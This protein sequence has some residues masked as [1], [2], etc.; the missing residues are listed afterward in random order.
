MNAQDAR[1]LARRFL[2]LPAQKRRIFLQ[3]LAR[4]KV[5]FAQFAIPA[6]VQAAER[7]LP[8]YAQQR[9]WFLWQLE[10][11]G[12]AYNLPGAVGLDGPLD[13][14]ALEQALQAL[15]ERHETLRSVLRQEGEQGLRLV[16][17]AQGVSIDFEDLCGLDTAAAEQ[18]VQVCAE[19][20]AQLP[21]DLEHGPLWRVRLLELGAER[22]V[23]LLTLHH[24][25]SDGWSMNVLIDEFIRCYDAFSQGQPMPL[26]ALPI[27]YA[28]Y[29]LWQRAWLEA[30]EQER[31]L[32]YWQQVLGDEHPV[33]ELPT[34][35][36][37]PATPSHR[38]TRHGFAVDAELAQQLRALAQQHQASLFMVLLA[39]FDALLYRYSGQG[40]LRVGVPIANRNRAEVEGLIGFFVNTQVL[41]CRIDEHLSVA[42]L[43]AQ[44]R[45][46]ALGAQAHQELP[47]ERLVEALKLERSLAHNPLFQVMYNHQPLVTDLTALQTASGIRFDLIQWQGR[48][49]QFDLSLDT[50]EKGG[51]L[52][53]ALTYAD[54][55][56]DAPTIQ[57]MAGHW[58][59]LL[60]AMVADAEQPVARLPMLGSAE[61]QQ[62]LHDWNPPGEGFD[63]VSR[64]DQC[65]AR[66]AAAHPDALALT[67]GLEQYSYGQLERWANRLAQRLVAA[68][69][70]PE[71]R[72]GVALP[73]TP[74]LLVSL[75]AVFKAGGAYVPLDPDYPAERVA[76]M[77]QDSAAH[78]VISEPEVAGRLALADCTEVLL[79]DGDEHSLAAWP[80]SA[81][82]NHAVAQN[83]AYVIYT[84]GSTGR[85]KGVAITHRNVLALLHWSR[86]VYTADDIQ[87]VLASTSICFDLSVWELFVTLAAGGSI[88]LARNALE[89][90]QLPA[91]D[92]VRLVNTVPSAITALLRDGLLPASVRIVNLA[93]EPLKQRVV[94]ALYA[95]PGLA[96]VFDL[97]GPSEDTTYSTWTRRQAGGRASIGRP[98]PHTAAYLLD[99]ALQPV[100]QGCSA[101]LYLAG[102][103]I[104]RGYLG[105]PGLTAERFVPDPFAADG[106]RLYRTG[107]LLRY[108]EQG[109]LEY[110]GRIDHQVK[111][112]GFR[113]ELGEIEARLQ[114]QAQV[115]EVAVLAPEGPSGRQ[116]V[117]YVVPADA[118]L[119]ADPAGQDTLREQL[120]AA[121]GE[122]LPDYMVP[123]AMPLLA[124]LPL[125]PN[126]KLDRKAL[127]APDA[128]HT[129]RE[130][131]PP[132]GERELALAQIWQALLGLE[133]VGAQDNFFELGGDS[134]VSMQVVS[135]AR[136]AGLALTPKDI[137][138]FQ[139]IRGLAMVAG[140]ATQLAVR[141]PASGEV[142]LA[143]IQHWF[144]EQAIADR[145]HW[146]QALLLDARAPLQGPALARAVEQLVAHHDSLRLRFEQRDGNWHQHYAEEAGE[147]F[148]QCTA[149]D[150][151]AALALCEQAQRSLDL[152]HGPLL[153]VLLIELPEGRQQ[154][155]LA[156]HH[157]VVDGVSWRIL[158]EDLEGLYRQALAGQ[159]PQLPARTSSYQDWA[160][161]LHE[162]VP[163]LQAQLPW[164]REHL[165]RAAV[166]ELPCDNPAGALLN[167]HAQKLECRFDAE[168]TRELLQVA[169]AAYRTQVNDLLLTALARVLCRWT[170]APGAL[171]ELEG[172][173]RETLFAELDL[174]RSVGWFTSLH[175]V[176]LVPEAEPGAALMAIK[177]Q[178]RAVPDKGIGH[179]LLRYL[180]D[181][182]AAAE[183]A[184]LPRPRVTFNYLGQ[185]DHQFDEQALLLPASHGAGQ[186]QG[187]D[188]PLA[189]WLTVEGHVY[190][191]ELALQ[192]GFST[193]MFAAQRI[194]ALVDDFASELRA[195][196][197]HC[198]Q[199][200]GQA[201][202][203]DFPLAGLDAAALAQLPVPARQLED[204]YPL[205]PMQQGMLFHS[206]YGQAGGDYVN[207][208]RVDVDGLDPA[209]LRKAWQQALDAH[210][211]L[212]TGFAWQ[213][214]QARPLQMVLR[215]AQLPWREL[216][217]RGRD[218]LAQ[219]LQVLAEQDRQAG[220]DLAQAPL[221]RLTLVRTGEDR[222]HLVQTS[223]HLLLDGWSNS[224]LLGEVLQR[225]AGQQVAPPVGLYRDY[226]QWLGQ[227]DMAVS[228]A[229][230][231]EQLAPLE[232]PTRLAHA[233]PAAG[234][235]GGASHGD[236]YQTFDD[237]LGAR[238]GA[239][240]R[241]QKVTVNTLVQAAWLL[242]L[243]RCTGQ[244]CVTFGATVAGRPAQLPGIE[245]QIGLFINT[246]PVIARPALQQPLGDWLQQVQALNLALREHEHTPLY[247]IQRWSGQGN[248]ALFDTLLVFEN[249][250]LSAALG[251]AQQAGVR[252]GEV[253]NLERTNY[254]LTL[255]V[256]LGEHLQVHYSYQC[257]ALDA[258][259]VQALAAQLECLLEQF[260]AGPQQV[261]AALEIVTPAARQALLEMPEALPAAVEPL[262]LHQMIEAQ[263]RRT[264]EAIALVTEQRTLSYASLDSQASDLARR[265]V[266]E[267]VGPEVLV[268]ISLP[269]GERLIIGLL[270]ILK[271]GGAYVPLDPEYPAQRLGHML[272][273][274][275]VTLVL[276]DARSAALLAGSAARLLRVDTLQLAEH[277]VQAP[278]PT[279]AGG[280]LLC[281]LFT[282]GST[283][284]P[285]GVALEQGALLR[286]LL[287]MQRSYRI[288]SSDRFLHFASLN[289]DW[290]T[291]QWLLPLISGARC[292]LRGEGLWSAEQALQVIEREQA[293]LVY[294]PTQ[295]ACQM[296]AWAATH[297]GAASVRSFNVAG[298]AFPREGFEQIQ[299]QLRPQ[300]IV[301]GYGPTETVITPFLWEASADT[302]FS[303]AYAP[304][305]RPVAGRSAYLLAE[306]LALQ[307]DGVVGELYI[308]GEAL[309][310]GY[311]GRPSQ[312]AERFVPDPFASTPG[313]RLYRSGDL[314][315]RLAD[316]QMEYI[317]RVDHQV[318]IRGF[319]V[320]TG[321]IEARLLA[322]P[323]VAAAAVVAVPG[324]VGQQLVAYVVPRQPLAGRD[325]QAA[326]CEALRAALAGQLAD[327]MQ[328]AHWQVLEQLPLTPNGKL[329]RKA[330]P[331]PDTSLL[332]QAFEAPRTA[333][334]AELA[335][336]WC[337]LLGLERVGLR[338][339]FFD[340]GGHSLLA[341]QVI[342][343]LR[344]THGL[345]LALRSLFEAADLQAFAAAVEACAPGTSQ[346]AA[347]SLQAQDASVRQPLSYAQQRL[348]FLW[349][350][351][352]HSSMYNIPR[353][354]QLDG[355]LDIDALRSAFEALLQRHSVLRTTYLQDAGDSWQQVH[356]Q[357]PLALT[358]HD[359]SQVPAGAREAA[360]AEALAEQAQ[361]PFDLV[362]GPVLRVAVLRLAEQQHL[363][364]VT[365]H[366]IVADHWSFGILLREFVALYDAAVCRTAPALPAPGL[367]YLDFAVWQRQWLAAGQLERQ[368]DYWQRTLGDDH[369]LTRLP[370][371]PQ[372]GVPAGTCQVHAF[373]FPQ[374]LAEALRGAAKARGLTL[375]M[376]LLAGF[377]LV[378]AQRC[379]STRVRLGTD[380]A[381]RNHAGVEEMVGFFVNQLVLQLTL[382][383]SLSAEQWLA[384]CRDVV[385]GASDHQDLPFDRLVEALRLPRQAGRSPL[386][387]IK[388]IYQEGSL[389]MQAPQGL[390][391]TTL[392]AGQGATELDLIAEF[393]NAEQLTVAFKCDASLYTAADMQGVFSQLQGV[394]EQLLEAPQAPLV[395]LLAH[396]AQLQA[397]AEQAQAQARQAQLKAQHPIRRRARGVELQ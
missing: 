241:Q 157:L 84:S 68:G 336:L 118:A 260:L 253:A 287:T 15:A 134:I 221:L 394:F 51:Q 298:E 218:D 310:R 360:I 341:T 174:S 210:A 268:G 144:F 161:S 7:G 238:L 152:A 305:G 128:L 328:P 123:A 350:L 213:G 382:D 347:P 58:L 254:P 231:R 137:F 168:L 392:E 70:G 282:S 215:Q 131:V 286:H 38:G 2:E 280:N 138:Q 64:I 14:Q 203:S 72:V 111:V 112:R 380:V 224:Q 292:I 32:A 223:H 344:H 154:L 391:V 135:R 208:M 42:G 248:D 226:I 343:R 385:A 256:T 290:G 153:R 291:E 216:D 267:G 255:A 302:R 242:L 19:Q 372:A 307:P 395:Q 105:R 57:R 327:Y 381:N 9:M 389:P 44:V 383:D 102:A 199:A 361:A 244:D 349:Q 281:L 323:S 150:A 348:W 93:G 151:D 25:V 170:G 117:A 205:S 357:V 191:G 166:A 306:G 66:Q 21:F 188:A 61:Q 45:D 82:A 89:L 284:R 180:G 155:L 187:A 91:R 87:G 251:Q 339:N 356:P 239:F 54:E 186:G 74:Q 367:A 259:T 388:F 297:G 98:L 114:A 245:A 55:L 6:G 60:R 366:H 315:R 106:G 340:L 312:T 266:A 92:Q 265:L 246:L 140:Q 115:S 320:E 375:Y 250:P 120:R 184:A 33:L 23:L 329:D 370:G 358:R 59:N 5:D 8:S 85:P 143:P 185:F 132:S 192:F 48:T 229:F 278:A 274:S 81:P 283:G 326:L 362:N 313:A 301:N 78:L 272:E 317:G 335:A 252:F 261:L 122:H 183:L 83:L 276:G 158:L 236:V 330:L 121:L 275:G 4:E 309:A 222:H 363:L 17:A 371:S 258:A 79:V 214:E 303:S 240:A 217:W 200:P 295:Y 145:Q 11:Q 321:E 35:H 333:L 219:A 397:S 384:R 233:L 247:E 325:A 86:G 167:R 334:Q 368:L 386:F 197:S 110:I 142:P 124:A 109:E 319:R 293:S 99:N 273:D 270:A 285:K 20:Q 176:L 67:F 53:A 113:I 308:G 378:V 365:L 173:G 257:A 228:E 80:A 49:T 269:R 337:E 296:A 235:D 177:E 294:F 189:N 331:A 77:L 324:P 97:Y 338:D 146:N 22:H 352:P 36:P 376:L 26:A 346:Q 119:L 396:A 165:G 198:L 264:P 52:H 75:L 172:H 104:T 127:P 178:L 194:Q 10:P 108:R 373:D 62:L 364:L 277:G 379:G 237:A 190:G 31:Q 40:E 147:V 322:E 179:G 156:L 181:A 46:T 243:Q 271:A 27:Q 18:Q 47:F 206:L 318:K 195:L 288:S 262:W 225:Y 316:G 139:T 136:E 30:G 393:V 374:P 211:I 354:L 96:H 377:S 133:Q 351:E 369:R 207:Q 332:Q 232:T 28:D 107:D 50:W 73:R 202:A 182:V 342:S 159:A 230:W 387:A 175:P 41:N 126:G 196:V 129:Q 95:L 162:A 101:E 1:N 130:H 300:H 204:L 125:T 34:D 39:A 148:G 13:R 65:I 141:G 29:A 100:A 314:V 299:R 249:Y 311:H 16:P 24:I 353:A 90:P 289:F 71:T 193:Q 103:G 149:T 304:I 88:V 209:R 345:D 227:Q 390:Q 212:R 163:G 160:R 56:F 171:I 37:R 3:A 201:T 94:D 43:I 355:E 169:P 76:Y 263:A 234:S 12:A 359:L 279:L 63:Q 164:W 220:F 69:V 116:L